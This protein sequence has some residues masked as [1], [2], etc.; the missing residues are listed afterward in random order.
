[1]E[2]EDEKAFATEI[3]RLGKKNFPKSVHGSGEK[4][5]PQI[6]KVHSWSD[7]STATA[8][9]IWSDGEVGLTLT[10]K[11]DASGKCKI[12]NPRRMSKQELEQK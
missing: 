9:A 11:F 12:L 8:Y 10:L 5:E 2:E 4:A 6:L 3:V 1:M 7:A